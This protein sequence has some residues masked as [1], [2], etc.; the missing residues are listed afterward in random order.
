M[1]IEWEV[2]CKNPKGRRNWVPWVRVVM[3]FAAIQVR[4]I[5]E[6][7]ADVVIPELDRFLC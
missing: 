6:L 4:V 7:L 5:G 3:R 1:G 2:V